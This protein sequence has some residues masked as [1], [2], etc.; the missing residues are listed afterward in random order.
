MQ[1]LYS[2]YFYI[3]GLAVLKGNEDDYNR[4]GMTDTDGGTNFIEDLYV[5]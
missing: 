3:L 1:K 2:N 4:T 5:S